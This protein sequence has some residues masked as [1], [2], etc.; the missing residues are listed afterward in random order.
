M[1]QLWA[2]VQLKEKKELL[3]LHSKREAMKEMERIEQRERA[4]VE[5]LKTA[6]PLSF[7]GA[8]EAAERGVAGLLAK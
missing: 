1:R 8:I 7:A 4:L 3:L 6:S 2:L 5:R